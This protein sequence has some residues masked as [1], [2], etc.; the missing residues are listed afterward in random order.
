MMSDWGALLHLTPRS[1]WHSYGTG[2]SRSP[3]DNG[4]EVRF[5]RSFRRIRRNSTRSNEKAQTDKACACVD[6]KLQRFDWSI[7]AGFRTP[8]E[9]VTNTSGSMT[10]HVALP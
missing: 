6:G 1:G 10:V 3:Q 7:V 4:I 9:H 5:P 2:Q 8:G